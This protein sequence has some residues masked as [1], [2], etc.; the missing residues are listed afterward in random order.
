MT[1]VKF[2]QKPFN[3]S[4]NNFLDDFFTDLP[5]FSKNEPGKTALMPVNIKETDKDYVLEVVAPGFEKGDF[6]VTVDQQ[7]LIV[8]AEKKEESKAENE[9]Q[10]RREYSYR[11]FERSF[12]I[13]E[14]IDVNSVAAKYENGVLTLNL[15][16]KEDVKA[17]KQEITIQ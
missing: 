4:F 5:V 15:P 6:K 13:D 8:S 9:K 1:L 16:K 17:A 12:T 10:I 11:S 7:Q 14:K 3:R 2:N